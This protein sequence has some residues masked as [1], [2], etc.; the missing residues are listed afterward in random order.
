MKEFLIFDMLAE[1]INKYLSTVYLKFDNK[2]RNESQL[3]LGN[4]NIFTTEPIPTPPSIKPTNISL[5][6]AT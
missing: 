5:E 1:A 6:L 4:K 3:G 2:H